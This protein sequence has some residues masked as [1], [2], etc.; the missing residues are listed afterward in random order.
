MIK[1]IFFILIFTIFIKYSYAIE[2]T[3]ILKL[4][5]GDVEIEL[6]KEIAPNH[7]ERFQKLAK[8]K[9]EEFAKEVFEED[10]AQGNIK[11]K[12]SGASQILELKITPDFVDSDDLDMLEDSMIYA[13]K[14]MY[15]IIDTKRTEALNSVT[16]ALDVD[17]LN[18]DYSK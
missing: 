1:K 16:G 13:M 2:N 14:K 4:K 15:E 12:M 8:E 3:M 7:A 10:F 5:D 18:F 9:Q 11:V 6:F 17:K